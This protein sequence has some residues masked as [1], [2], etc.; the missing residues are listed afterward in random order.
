MQ[1]QEFVEQRRVAL[2]KYLRRLAA[3]PVIRKSDEFRVFLQV[4][5]RLPLPSTTDVASRVLDGAAK[6]PKQLLGES[7]IAPH[8]VVQPA[9][10]GRDLMRLFKELRQS[11]A[12]D[13]GGSRPAVVEE[14]KE[15]LEK[16][17]KIHELEQQ[18]NGASQQV[19][20]GFY[21]FCES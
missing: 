20:F 7:V 15:F 13:W 5:G 2:E 3:H 17:E 14:D 18:I 11:V 8:E 1:K 10:G 9:R 12:N 4:Q 16:K 6:L 21:V 19:L